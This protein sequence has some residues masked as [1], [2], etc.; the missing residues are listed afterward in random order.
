MAYSSTSLSKKIWKSIHLQVLEQRQHL[1]NYFKTL[2]VGPTGN[3][4]WASYT[5]DWNLT[6]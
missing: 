1:L 6:N 2:S 5:I 3:Q 4:T